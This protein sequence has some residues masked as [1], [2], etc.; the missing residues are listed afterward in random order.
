MIDINEQKE[1]AGQ[2]LIFTVP[3]IVIMNEGKEIFKESRFI[4]FNKIERTLGLLVD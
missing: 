2:N 3:T 4:D 1:I